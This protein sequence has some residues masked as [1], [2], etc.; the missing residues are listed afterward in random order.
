[1]VKASV[2]AGVGREAV[3]QWRWTNRISICRKVSF[4]ILRPKRRELTLV[5]SNWKKA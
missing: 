2:E 5:A 1:M 3:V 4:R